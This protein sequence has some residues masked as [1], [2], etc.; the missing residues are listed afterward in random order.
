MPWPASLRS[1]GSRKVFQGVSQGHCPACNGPQRT[2]RVSCYANPDTALAHPKSL[3]AVVLARLVSERVRKEACAADTSRPATHVSGR[4]RRA[5]NRHRYQARERAEGTIPCRSRQV[6]STVQKVPVPATSPRSALST[7]PERR[8]SA[9]L[10]PCGAC[11]GGC[12]S[13]TRHKTRHMCT[14]SS[15]GAVWRTPKVWC[16]CMV[17]WCHGVMVSWCHGVMVSCDDVVM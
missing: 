6:A 5:N 9:K 13:N 10:R 7:A 12:G 16:M 1:R 4:G 8:R 14:W 3:K 2:T 17:S 11:A 15:D